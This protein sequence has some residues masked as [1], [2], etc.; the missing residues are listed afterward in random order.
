LTLDVA[1]RHAFPGFALDATFAA[2]AG[3]TALF[4]PS[5]SGKT[6]IVK[7][8]AGL[9]APDGGRIVADGAPEAVITDRLLAD[10]YRVGLRVNVASSSVFVLPGS[11]EF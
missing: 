6:T 2:P 5:G 4:G 1:L 10:T 9:L 3:V 7:A 11:R 8:I